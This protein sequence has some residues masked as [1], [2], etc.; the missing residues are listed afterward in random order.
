MGSASDIV[1]KALGNAC[2]TGDEMFFEEEKLDL[3][4]KRRKK[5]KKTPIT[6]RNLLLTGYLVLDLIFGNG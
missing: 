2:V 4:T 1:A 5:A 6:R 3:N